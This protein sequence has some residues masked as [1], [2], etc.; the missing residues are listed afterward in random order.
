MLNSY[1]ILL[2]CK[3]DYC[4]GVAICGT[5]KVLRALRALTATR[6]CGCNALGG[7]RNRKTIA[8]FSVHQHVEELSM[9]AWYFIVMGLFRFDRPPRGVDAATGGFG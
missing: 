3:D 6:D 5:R 8:C 2:S 9:H 4:G 1:Q 7:R